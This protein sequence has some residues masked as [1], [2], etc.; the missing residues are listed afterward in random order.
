MKNFIF[1]VLIYS[2]FTCTQNPFFE[3]ENRPDQRL[4]ILGNVNLEQEQEHSDTFIWLE[5]IGASTRTDSLG[6]FKLEL[7][8]PE[9]LPGGALAWTGKY[10]LYF[11]QSNF[12][13]DTVSVFLRNGQVEYGTSIVDSKG[14]LIND[15]S[16]FKL[17]LIDVIVSPDVID[18]ARIDSIF[19]TVKVKPLFPSIRIITYLK[20]ERLIGSLFFQNLHK[21]YTFSSIYL[22]KQATYFDN[23]I[24][25][26]LGGSIGID[27]IPE[28]G[29]YKVVPYF[30][31]VQENLPDELSDSISKYV[32]TF[33]IEYL[34]LPIKINSNVFKVL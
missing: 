20:D 14:K 18:P 28:S 22:N 30:R 6:N 33:T 32:K 16:L 27:F 3:D 8:A 25:R 31:I 5:G 29:F 13:F 2:L 4:T 19:V 15:I 23:N 12:R 9:T 26:E 17:A 21:D 10:K 24:S 11:Y 7:P 1:I 34:K